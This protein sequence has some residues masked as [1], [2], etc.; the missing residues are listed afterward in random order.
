MSRDEGFIS[1]FKHDMCKGGICTTSSF[2]DNGN[3]AREGMRV[4]LF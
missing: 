2:E 4:K 3:S 1:R